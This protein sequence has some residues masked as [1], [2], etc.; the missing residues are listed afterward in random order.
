MD[1]ASVLATVAENLSHPLWVIGRDLSL[2]HFNS[3]F[4]D[5]CLRVLGF[6]P[7]VEM[8]MDQLI[9]PVRHAELRAWW[10][11]MYRR[12]LS[13]R[14]VLAD[15]WY[16]LEGHKR[17]FSMSGRPIEIDGSIA[18]ATFIARDVTD[19]SRPERDDLAELALKRLFESEEPLPKILDAALELICDSG[20]WQCAVAWLVD[21][22]QLVPI[23]IWTAPSINSVDFAAHV[24]SMRFTFGHGM[25]GR[26]WAAGDIIWVPDLFDETGMQRGDV[27]MRTGLHAVVAVPLL[28]SGH[29]AGIIELFAS[30][31][32]PISPE[33]REALRRN[34][35]ALAR[36]I[37]RRRA[38]DERRALQQ[39]I[40]R[41]GLEWELTFDALDLP[42]FITTIDGTILRVNRAAG[43]LVGAAYADALGRTLSAIGPG[44]P[45]K[46]LAD[47][48]AAV[49]DS[50]SPCTAQ[51]VTDGGT[52]WD[53]NASW[54]YSL[55]ET[56]ARIII[57]LRD[58]SNIVRL[59]ESVRR[60]E[61]LAALGELVAG[62]AHEVR[63]PLFGMSATLD[64]LQPYIDDTADAAELCEAMRQWLARLNNLMENLLHYGK[65]WR[66]HLQEGEVGGAIAQAVEV[67]RRF[68]ADAG[69]TLET[70][71]RASAPILMDASR[72]GLV[73]ENLIRNAVQHSRPKDRVI[74]SAAISG[75]LVE[76]AVSDDGPGFAPADVPH[77]FEPFYTK[78]RGGSG[79]GLAIVQRIVE[80]HGGTV[81][82]ENRSQGG[83]AVILRFPVYDPLRLTQNVQRR[84]ESA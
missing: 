3:A 38:D 76:C 23:S 46:T 35:A 79:L 71:I 80:E 34:G 20:E 83:A 39:A 65:T 29:T 33:L 74:I 77:V 69:V 56:D 57:V 25:P 19:L 43:D 75:E 64:L 11:D 15:S 32:R 27:A 70:D 81:T 55:T 5:L 6:R 48:V 2:T 59:Q 37:E 73:F 49:R 1:A 22:A 36:L 45:W 67:C 53:V 30:A 21:G 14:T 82:A 4:S 84:D 61:Q 13:G 17:H 31:A 68:A 47:T 26:A 66:M 41:K 54:F 50:R 40:Q 52:Y 51:S 16:V 7:R 72:L 58:V 8:T 28:A 12:A 63:N 60:G 42:I 24:S 78:R 62:V 18:G 10:L 9:D 44:E